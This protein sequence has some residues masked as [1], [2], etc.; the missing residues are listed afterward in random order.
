MSKN[1]EL[2]QEALREMERGP[3]PA[4]QSATILFPTPVVESKS[5][6]EATGLDRVAHEECLKLVQRIFLAQP[7]TTRRTVAFAGIDRGNGCSR[8][9]VETARMLAA[10]T[11]GSVCIVDAHF[12][13]PSLPEFFGVHNHR[14]LAESLVE[15]GDILSF[16]RQLTP[17][18]LWLLSAGGLA[19]S[20]PG[21][22]NSDR[23]KLRIDELRKG[24]D[25][26]LVDVAAVN[27]YADAI[28]V[29]R[30]TDGV[31]VVL[32]ADSTRRESALKGLKSLREAN[33]EVL[34]AVLNKRTFPIPDF[35]YRRL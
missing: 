20:S 14:G 2:M 19:Q 24:F 33:I 28:A 7:S 18:N 11:S 17:S 31:V 22:L 30:I 34:G 25:F 10:N 26:V 5:Q 3:S 32:Q 16:A 23:L 21:L 12:R 1:F 6:Q 15:A 35:L 29:G 8:I 13:N 27:L 9:C 4:S